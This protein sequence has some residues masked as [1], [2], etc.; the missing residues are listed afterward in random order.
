MKLLLSQSSAVIFKKCKLFYFPSKV[1]KQYI[2]KM[3]ESLW[4]IFI[5]ILQSFAF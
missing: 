5:C 3:F 1:G 2:L 4:Y